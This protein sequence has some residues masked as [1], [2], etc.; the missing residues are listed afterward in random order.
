[1]MVSLEICCFILLILRLTIDKV[2]LSKRYLY[3]PLEGFWLGINGKV[4]TI[5]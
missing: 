1:V 5:G 3:S 2:L 4:N